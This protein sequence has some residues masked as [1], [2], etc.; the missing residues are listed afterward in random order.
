MGLRAWRPSVV[1]G[2]AADMAGPSAFQKVWLLFAVVAVALVW[3]WGQVAQRPAGEGSQ[4]GVDDGPIE[5]LRVE[6]G[7]NLAVSPCAAYGG[8]LGLVAAVNLDGD[9]LRW[10]FRLADDDGRF[11]RVTAALHVPGRQARMLSVIRIGDHWQAESPGPAVAGSF[12][13]VRLKGGDADWLADFPLRA[14]N[15]GASAR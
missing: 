10:R 2:A 11:Q 4:P 6:A 1:Y 8:G 7:C 5:L 12:L 15:A 3:V 14:E 13:R 9:G